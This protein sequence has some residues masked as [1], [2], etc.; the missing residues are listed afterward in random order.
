MP[1]RDQSVSILLA[2]LPIHSSRVYWCESDFR[3]L[4]HLSCSA[5]IVLNH[6]AGA[7]R[8]EK[9]LA[10]EVDP[11]NR[12]AVLTEPYEIEGWTGFSFP[13][14][15]KKYSDFKVSV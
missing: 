15:G 14:R 9:F 2:F 3:A 8:T 5:D 11:D 4:A 1:V 12:E 7:D 6:K 10:K 13:G